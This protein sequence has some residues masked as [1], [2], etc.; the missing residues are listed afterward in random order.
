MATASLLGSYVCRYKI[1][2]L[3]IGSV[4]IVM[5]IL[6]IVDNTTLSHL[7][8]L[9]EKVSRFYMVL[10]LDLENGKAFVENY[11]DEMF[12]YISKLVSTLHVSFHFSET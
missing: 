7:V 9:L 2:V 6:E 3:A 8:L 12:E 11:K 10:N 4:Y 1:S 5:E